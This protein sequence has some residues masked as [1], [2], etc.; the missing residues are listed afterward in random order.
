MKTAM[1]VVALAACGSGLGKQ[2]NTLAESVTEFN[3]ALRWSQFS[4]AAVHLPAKQ[5]SQFVDEWDER[6]KDLKITQYDVVK[7]DQKG[8]RSASVQVK[9]EWYKDSEGTVHETH[10][11]QTW[12]KHGKGWFLVDES[13]LRGVEMP[14]LP[15]PVAKD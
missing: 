4:N 12:E 14:G 6:A 11:I 7:V 9:M 2:E 13:R 3:E 1:L 10:A 15:E 8:S 5:R